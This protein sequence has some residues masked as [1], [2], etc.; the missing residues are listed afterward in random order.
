MTY[1]ELMLNDNIRQVQIKRE[2]GWS[3]FLKECVTPDMLKGY[4]Y[5]TMDTIIPHCVVFGKES[6]MKDY[7][8]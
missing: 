5:I 8:Y 6:M 7:F 3:T 4:V 2:D 1:D